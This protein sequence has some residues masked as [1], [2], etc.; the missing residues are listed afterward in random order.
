MKGKVDYTEMWREYGLTEQGK[1]NKNLFGLT[2]D[3][4]F[5][6]NKEIG[7][8]ELGML[9]EA[10]VDDLFGRMQIDPYVVPK[11]ER[12]TSVDP[13]PNDNEAPLETPKE[14]SI[15]EAK[16]PFKPIQN[17]KSQFNEPLKWFDVAG[18][19]D[20][21]LSSTSRFPCEIRFS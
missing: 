17:P 10:Y 20:S 3:G 2:K 19:I 8:K 1:K 7:E 16:E 5:D 13:R 11:Q 9:K 21:L 12:V 18:P 15:P 6:P 4:V 14:V